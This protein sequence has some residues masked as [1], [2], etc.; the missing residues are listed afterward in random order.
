[1]EQLPEKVKNLTTLLAQTKADYLKQVQAFL[2]KYP[3]YRTQ[4]V[5]QQSV[6][7]RALAKFADRLPEKMLAVQFFP[8]L[9][10]L[11]VFVVAPGGRFEVKRQ[12]LP[13][14]GLY[15][16]IKEYRQ[17]LERAATQRLPWRDLPWN[18]D[19]SEAYRR[20]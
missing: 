14:A 15:K 8:S 9:D 7:P 18:D 10:A 12:E 3:Q 20:D 2:A 13:Q 17:Y 19:G 4:F 6:D 11:Y 1:G 16:L 5:D